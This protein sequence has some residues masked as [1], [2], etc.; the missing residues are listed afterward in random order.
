MSNRFKAATGLVFGEALLRIR[1]SIATIGLFTLVFFLPGCGSDRFKTATVRGKVTY[2][3]KPVPN[4]TINF[5]PASGPSASGEIQ[6]DGSYTLT[7]YR[8][9]DGA[10]PGSYTVVIVA[11]A[12]MSGKLPENR[13]PLPPS[14]V[15][16][17]YTNVATSPLRAGVKDQENIID[18]NLE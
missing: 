14:I 6:R 8:S 5:M 10:A 17:K 2:K 9:G 12:D 16:D 18:F 11:M 3:G 7:T 1:T 13:N 4:G 15:P